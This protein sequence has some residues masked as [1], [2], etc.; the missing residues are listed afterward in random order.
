MS[1]QTS[2]LGASSIC[3]RGKSDINVSHG[4][5][6]LFK[7][8]LS[9]IC[10]Q[11]DV[12]ESPSTSEEFVPDLPAT[13][14]AIQ[15]AMSDWTK[16][17]HNRLVI[18]PRYRRVANGSLAHSDQPSSAASPSKVLSIAK[19]NARKRTEIQFTGVHPSDND[20]E[21]LRDELQRMSQFQDHTIMVHPPLW[22]ASPAPKRLAYGQ[23]S[24]TDTI[25]PAIMREYVEGVSFLAEGKPA[26]K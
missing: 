20:L 23:I 9:F 3:T 12:G 18:A 19:L 13:A 5:A 26:R 10:T 11:P 8:G 2:A 1:K 16:S 15:K 25:V 24:N 21:T 6:W 14:T 17:D 4:T 22:S 7:D